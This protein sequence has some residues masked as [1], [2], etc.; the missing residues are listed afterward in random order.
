M[1]MNANSPVWQ[2]MV[3]CK[4]ESEMLYVFRSMDI[5]CAAVFPAWRRSGKS[6]DVN[7]PQTKVFWWKTALALEDA[8]AESGKRARIANI[9]RMRPLRLRRY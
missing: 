8:Q 6:C 2:V 1:G 5:P 9:S 3:V 4:P 7:S